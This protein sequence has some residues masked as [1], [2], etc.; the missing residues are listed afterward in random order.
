MFCLDSSED[1]EAEGTEKKKGS[2]SVY[3]APEGS[4]PI[5][6]A[7]HSKPCKNEVECVHH[8]HVCD[9]EVDCSDGSDEENCTLECEAGETL[10]WKADSVILRYATI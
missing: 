3:V 1:R 2:A 10:K 9:G 6:C 4:A 7:F 8:L 5:Q